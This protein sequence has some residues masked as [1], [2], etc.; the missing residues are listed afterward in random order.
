[1]FTNRRS[2]RG[3]DRVPG[4]CWQWTAKGQC[5]KG[6]SCSFRHDENKRA[7]PTPMSPLASEPPTEKMVNTSREEGVLEAAVPQESQLDY[8]A[9]RFSASS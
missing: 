6:D 4:E 1:M 8:R 5:S 7:K 3:V 9:E 2:Q